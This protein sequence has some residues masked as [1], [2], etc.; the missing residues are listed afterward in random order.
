MGRR[1]AIRPKGKQVA[2]W[3]G[4]GRSAREFAKRRTDLVAPAAYVAARMPDSGPVYE[5]RVRGHFGP[6]WREAFSP[7]AATC[8]EGGITVLRG[9]I[10]DQA[11]LHGVLRALERTGIV[12]LSLMCVEDQAAQPCGVGNRGVEGGGAG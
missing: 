8:A 11:A 10:C 12:L 5:I 4:A 9:R 1:G 6:R 7:L 2:Y 3:P